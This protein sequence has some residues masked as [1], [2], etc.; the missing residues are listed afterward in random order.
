MN[1]TVIWWVY[2]DTF[3]LMKPLLADEATPFF[4]YFIICVIPIS[5]IKNFIKF[6]LALSWPFHMLS[7]FRYLKST[8]GNIKLINTFRK[9]ELTTENTRDKEVSGHWLELILSL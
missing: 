4:V 1:N 7:N 3:W 8:L 2:R 6:D 5:L 9:E